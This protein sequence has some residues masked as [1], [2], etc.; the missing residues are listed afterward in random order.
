MGLFAGFSFLSFVEIVNWFTVRLFLEKST[1]K[2]TPFDGVN[3]Q[4][5]SLVK[6]VKNYLI[7]SSIHGFVHIAESGIIQRYFKNIGRKLKV[8]QKFF[9]LDFCGYFTSLHQ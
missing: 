7:E 8:A 6:I 1:T 2:V 9:N 4:L 3:S 5:T